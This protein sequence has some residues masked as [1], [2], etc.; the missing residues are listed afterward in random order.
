MLKDNKATA[1]TRC[2]TSVANPTITSDS[3]KHI[4][5][6]NR[7]ILLLNLDTSHPEMGSPI[8]E[9]IGMASSRLP[10]S[11]SLK[12]KLDLIEGILAAQEAKQNPSKKKKILKEIRCADAFFIC[13][14]YC[15]KYP[16]YFGNIKRF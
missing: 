16:T 2:M 12:L 10:S 15:R 1:M 5:E 14:V 7:G 9:L 8:I 3:T 13:S 11:A 6:M 4:K